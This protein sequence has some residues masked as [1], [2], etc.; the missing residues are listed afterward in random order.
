M[1]HQDVPDRQGPLPVEPLLLGQRHEPVV[2]QDDMVHDV[3]GKRHLGRRGQAVG[4]ELAQIVQ[5]RPRGDDV[6]VGR[7]A[8][9]GVAPNEGEG[10]PRHG[11]RVLQQS[12]HIG[13]V[14]RHGG[15]PGLVFPP[16]APLEEDPRQEAPDGLPA[17]PDP[18]AEF[19]FHR[20]VGKR[21]AAHE[22]VRRIL[23]LIHA[24]HHVEVVLILVPKLHHL[25]HQ[26]DGAPLQAEGRVVREGVEAYPG[27]PLE[28]PPLGAAPDLAVYLSRPVHHR[29]VPEGIVVFILLAHEARGDPQ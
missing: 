24:V 3:A 8:G 2:P 16:Q 28:V 19:G 12:P 5:K 6:R 9:G 11:Q 17:G 18:L 22:A 27:V 25:A 13:V 7:N 15:G 14:D 20:L 26:P 4:L 21:R 23:L 10:R 29:D 1:A